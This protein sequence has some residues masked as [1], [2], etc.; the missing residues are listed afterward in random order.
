MDAGVWCECLHGICACDREIDSCGSWL[1][2]PCDFLCFADGPTQ[3][4][5]RCPEVAGD[6]RWDAQGE[7]YKETILLPALPS[8]LLLF[9]FIL[10]FP[11]PL[12][13]VLLLSPLRASF[14][15][16]YIPLSVQARSLSDLSFR[17]YPISNK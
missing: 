11:L 1:I 10:I 13:P 5:Q 15:L 8:F 12:F 16:I 4:R 9:L 6:G 7:A 3:M 14:Y 2:L 17:S